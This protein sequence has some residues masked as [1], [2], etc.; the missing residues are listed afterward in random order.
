M[1]SSINLYDLDSGKI[2]YPQL[3]HLTV[4]QL[5]GHE[6]QLIPSHF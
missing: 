6:S 5:I 2:S 4:L 1:L 3:G